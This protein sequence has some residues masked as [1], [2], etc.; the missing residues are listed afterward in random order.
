MP[1]RSSDI[2]SRLSTITM[3]LFILAFNIFPRVPDNDHEGRCSSRNKENISD[4]PRLWL[5][6]R[7]PTSRATRMP[8]L[9]ARYSSMSHSVLCYSSRAPSTDTWVRYHA[10]HHQCHL[11]SG[12]ALFAISLKF[13]TISTI[14]HR[15]KQSEFTIASIPPFCPTFSKKLNFSI[16][17]EIEPKETPKNHVCSKF[18]YRTGDWWWP[19]WFIHSCS[20]CTWG[21]QHRPVGARDIS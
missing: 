10:G 4:Q 16:I 2:C 11:T 13:G 6:R 8:P 15:D 21:Y 7:C 5:A 18:M 9:A 1:S 17:S 20:T 14:F 12:L 3:I 19:R